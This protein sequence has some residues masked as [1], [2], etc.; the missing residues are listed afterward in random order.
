[1]RYRRLIM[2]F[3]M[4]LVVSGCAS[5]LSSIATDKS[6]ED[7]DHLARSGDLQAEVDLLARP[8]VDSGRTPGLIVGVLTADGQ[9]HFYSYGEADKEKHTPFTPDTLVPVG[10]LTKGFVGTVADDL[11]R[12]GVLHWDDTL[13]KLLPGVPMTDESKQITLLELATHTS[14]MPRQPMVPSLLFRVARYEFTGDD[15]YRPYDTSYILGYL[16]DFDWDP[17]DRPFYSNTGYAV[18]GY[19][20]EKR[21]G[22]SLQTLLSKTVIGPLSL[23]STGFDLEQLPGH[24]ARARGYAGDEP[25]FV[26]RGKPVPDFQLT[27]IM[28]NTGGLYSSA[29]DI[30]TFAAA[31][32]RDDGNPLDSLLEDTLRVR[33]PETE[34]ATGIAWFVDQVDG[35]RIT[36]QEGLIGGFSAYLGLDRTHHTAVVVFENSFNWD[37]TI[38]HRLLIRMAK[39]EESSGPAVSTD[40]RAGMEEE[41]R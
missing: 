23:Q 19:I 29:H 32:V 36:Y 18:L 34:G 40:T 26:R 14:G 4:T 11:V 27:D 15:F 7:M 16:D 20:I 8:R 38:G 1:M 12:Q 22:E 35:E 10:S 28:K 2:T 9:M 3:F 25:L 30:L 13:E 24:E 17:T 39:A 31:C 41:Q 6:R 37:F 33:V 21:T 5:T